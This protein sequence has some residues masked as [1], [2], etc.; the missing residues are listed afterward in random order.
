MRSI[1]WVKQL[2]MGLTAMEVLKMS[3]WYGWIKHIWVLVKIEAV[4]VKER[5]NN[6][7]KSENPH[8]LVNYLTSS[9]Y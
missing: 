8:V 6:L 4:V 9:P 7:S 2:E 5:Q 3:F 1:L